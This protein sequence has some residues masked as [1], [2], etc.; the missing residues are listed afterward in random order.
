MRVALL[1]RVAVPH[2]ISQKATDGVCSTG[3][4]HVLRS[5]VGII[6]HKLSIP[7]LGWGHTENPDI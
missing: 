6:S 3:E 4:K 2:T 1:V 5:R 7:D